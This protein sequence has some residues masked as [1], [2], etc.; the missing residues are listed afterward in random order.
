MAHFDREVE[1]GSILACSISHHIRPIIS[2]T[3]PELAEE[4]SHIIYKIQSKGPEGSFEVSRRYNDFVTLRKLLGK[5]WPGCYIPQIP[6]K[7]I[8]VK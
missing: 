8:I 7:K 3:S 2:V 6:S 1:I 4:G 5:N